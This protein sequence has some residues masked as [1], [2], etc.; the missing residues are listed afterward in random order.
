[1]PRPFDLNVRKKKWLILAIYKPPK[2]NSQYYIEEISRLIDRY[3]KFDYVLILG[4]FNLEPD[5][6]DVSSF[7]QEH[8]LYKLIKSKKCFKSLNGQ[9]IDLLLTNCK[10]SFMHS[11]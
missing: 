1:M 6:K 4:D 8:N 3:S 9:C 5:D 7:I 2:Q 10:N 11:I